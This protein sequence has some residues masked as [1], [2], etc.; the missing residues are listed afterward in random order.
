[1]AERPISRRQ[2]VRIQT[3]WALLCRQ[4]GLGKPSG[5]RG[6]RLAWLGGTL[7]RQ[8]ASTKELTLAEATASIDALQKCLPP[9]LLRRRARPGA[10][11]AMAMG[12]AGRRDFSRDAGRGSRVIELPGPAELELLA[13]LRAELGLDDARFAAFLRSRKGPL[14]GRERIETLADANRIIWALKGILRRAKKKGSPLATAGG[15]NV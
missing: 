13:T 12:R 2:L 11:R 15:S 3:L 4:Q 10:R 9:E 5:T 14:G 7:G 1:M 6:A 8:V